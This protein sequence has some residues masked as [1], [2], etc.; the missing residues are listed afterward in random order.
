M[1]FTFLFV[2]ASAPADAS[3]FLVPFARDFCRGDELRRALAVT[4]SCQFAG[5]LTSLQTVFVNL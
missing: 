5:Q 1:V 3:C 4:N 2:I